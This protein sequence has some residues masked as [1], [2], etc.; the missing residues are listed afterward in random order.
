MAVAD[1]GD[2]LKLPG[3][4]CINPTD[5][6]LDFPHGG[7]ALG[8][9][10][11]A[12]FRFGIQTSIVTAEEWGQQP[13]EAVYAGASA[14]FGCVLREW[15]NDAISA[16]FPNTGTGT[17]SGDST[18]LG[19][20]DGVGVNRAGHLFSAQ[21]LVL[22]FSPRSVDRHPMVL[23]RKALPMP[24]E[25]AMIQASLAQEF[26]IG[27]VFQAIPD[28]SDRTYDIGARGDLTL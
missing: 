3:R 18:I 25:T 21:A 1:V 16:I 27:V 24:D 11:A 28:S 12:E 15:D 13:V 17:I 2:V 10:R 20:V 26:G 5:L 22:L 6:S 19:R 7:T 9:T 23:V 8:L 4:L 14:V